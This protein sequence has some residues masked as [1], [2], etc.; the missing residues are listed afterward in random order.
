MFTI[1]SGL[2]GAGKTLHTIATNKKHTGKRPV[3]YYNIPL[4]EEG[5]KILGWIELTKEQVMT[6]YDEIPA[7]G[8][9]IVD[10]AQ[11][12]WPIRPA[13]KPVP[14]S[15]SEIET[16]RH[17]GVDLI[18]ITQDPTLLDSHARKLA[19]EHIHYVRPYGA[20]YAIRHHSGTGVKDVK[21]KAQL[22]AT[23]KS[24][25]GQPSDIFP[26]YK[27]AE[28]HTHKF[29]P[30][31]VLFIIPLL[32]MLVAYS[33]Y[34]AFSAITGGSS[35]SQQTTQTNTQQNG[36]ASK[37]QVVDEDSMTWPQLLK[38]EIPGL[39]YTAPLYRQKAMQ[40]VEVP[41]VAGCMEF[42][43]TCHCF[44]QQG[45]RINDVSQQVC[46]KWLVNRPFDHLVYQN[47]QREGGP[48]ES[49]AR[50]ERRSTGTPSTRYISSLDIKVPSEPY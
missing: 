43:N 27:S 6:W 46:R 48:D 18:F 2:P 16:H 38:P 9:L 4:S 30:P 37:S 17:K 25:I 26:L 32:L 7:N 15:L 10:E 12:L 31:K 5:A 45:S 21:S 36:P 35:A 3:F 41:R 33:I 49:S 19:N 44:T 28:V 23:T 14:R 47:Q 39:P 13:S 20:K 34:Y 1:V 8:I 42:E 11:Q 50:H 29:R 24:R 40:V 22:D